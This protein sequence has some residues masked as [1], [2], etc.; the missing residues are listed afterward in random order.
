MYCPR[1]GQQRV[2][3]E[4]RYCSRCGF[5]LGVVTALLESGGEAA[6]ADAGRRALT[7]QQIGTRKG[8]AWMAGA[9]AFFIFVAVI[10][11]MT[12][13]FVVLMIPAAVFFVVGLI[14]M[15]YGHLLEDDAPP[16]ARKT[17]AAKT[18]A[19]LEG[20]PP[21]ALPPARHNPAADFAATRAATAEMAAPPSVMEGTTKILKE[22]AD[23]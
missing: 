5:P 6:A 13:D 22:G 4:V 3:D 10:T 19:T 1:C 2:S 20:A 18:T 14:R 12:D 15:L 8:L 16:P 17:R 21:A 23:G 9:L 7:A 11:V